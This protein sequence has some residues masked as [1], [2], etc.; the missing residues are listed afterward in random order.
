VFTAALE[1]G[2]DRFVYTSSVAAY[3][4]HEENPVPLTEDVPARGEENHYYSHQKAELEEVLLEMAGG[5][6]TDVYVFRPC[7]VAGPHATEL[8]ENI[9][10]VQLGEKLPGPVRS[11]VGTIPLLRPVIPDPGTPFQL[12]HEDDVASALASAIEG[13]RVP[14]VYN[15][16]GPGELTLGDLAAALGWYTIPIPE[17]AVDMTAKVVSSLPLMPTRAQWI[18]AI[19]VP[20]LMDT[21]KARMNLGWA[22]RY[23]A[24]ETL[25]DTIA[26]AREKGLLPSALFSS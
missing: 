15:L 22:P 9:P 16:A 13:G 5:R 12:V 14:G 1:A 4:F 10:Y 25:A 11:L 24:M 3:G 19:S 26:G 6:K 23:D 2:V 18:Q 20:V 17:L 7:I 8:I 21:T